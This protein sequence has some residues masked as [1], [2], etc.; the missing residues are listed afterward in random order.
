[1]T[2]IHACR[3]CG[4]IDRDRTHCATCGRRLEALDFGVVYELARKR[5]YG[6]AVDRGQAGGTE[7]AREGSTR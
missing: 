5:H 7:I 4:R 1:M 2:S 3:S 6:G